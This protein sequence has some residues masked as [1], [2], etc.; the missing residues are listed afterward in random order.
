MNIEF[1]EEKVKNHEPEENNTGN[2]S[3]KLAENVYDDIM[4]KLGSKKI[5]QTKEKKIFTPDALN[6]II[7]PI[8]QLAKSYN[9][10]VKD[11]RNINYGKK[12]VFE[13]EKQLGEINVFYGKKGF[14]VVVTPKNGTNP[15]VAEIGE[16]IIWQVI[17]CME[18]K[19]EEK[20]NQKLMI[21]N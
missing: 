2:K 7:E 15:K 5:P 11:I 14:S 19:V 18:T 17:A 6:T 13:L 1:L 12:I 16:R 4:R 3:T 8:T 20:L 9:I 21:L 10:M